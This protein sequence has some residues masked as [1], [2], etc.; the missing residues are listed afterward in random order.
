MTKPKELPLISIMWAIRDSR[1]TR[2]AERQLLDALAMRCNP[3]KGYTCWPSYEMLGLDTGCNP[4]T[5]KKA[6]LA[7]EKMGLIHRRVRRNRSNIYTVHVAKILQQAEIQ[8]A[9]DKAKKDAL[10]A[11][12][13]LPTVDSGGLTLIETIDPGQVRPDT[14]NFFADCDDL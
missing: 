11:Y 3:S 13:A 14:N 12:D 10:V 7:L 1:C 8:R 2:N 9:V 4:A 5:L 6:A